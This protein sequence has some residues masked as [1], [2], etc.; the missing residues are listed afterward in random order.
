LGGQAARAARAVRGYSSGESKNPRGTQQKTGFLRSAAQNPAH[1][2]RNGIS[3]AT[4]GAHRH[5]VL[6]LSAITG[7]HFDEGSIQEADFTDPASDSDRVDHRDF[8]ICRGNGNLNLVGIGHF[9]LASRQ[10]I[11]FPDTMIAARP[12]RSVI[13]AAFLQST[14]NSAY[15][16]Q[17]IERLARTTNGTM[18]INQ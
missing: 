2:V 5:L 1:R 6:T 17:Q 9:P 12:K 4:G 14:W 11:L 7:S 13:H 16:R 18:K 10:D 8:L 15:V 3:P